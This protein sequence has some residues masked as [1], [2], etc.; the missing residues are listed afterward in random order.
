MTGRGNP[1]RGRP[2]G[3]PGPG[4]RL[5]ALGSAPTPVQPD[6]RPPPG[7]AS[8]MSATRRATRSAPAAAVPAGFR[9]LLPGWPTALLV[10]PRAS[11]S[12]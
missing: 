2:R 6:P 11:S 7:R 3:R 5:S 8:L 9:L 1:L 12:T 4:C 10:A